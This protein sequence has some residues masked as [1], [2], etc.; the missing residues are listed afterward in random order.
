MY[1]LVAE[2]LKK[3]TNKE[4]HLSQWELGEKRGTGVRASHLEVTSQFYFLS[5]EL[6]SDLRL[7][8][9]VRSFHREQ[10][11]QKRNELPGTGR[12]RGLTLP[13]MVTAS[14]RPATRLGRGEEVRGERQFPAATLRESGGGGGRSRLRGRAGSCLAECERVDGSCARTAIVRETEELFC[15][16]LFFDIFPS[17]SFFSC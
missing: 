2:V 3:Q 6:G 4:S 15:F 5:R 13:G 14:R 10:L 17:A 9:P 16:F 12:Q 11:L 8:R 7:V 1:W